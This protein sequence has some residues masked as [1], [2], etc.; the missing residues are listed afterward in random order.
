MTARI[1]RATAAATLREIHADLAARIPPLDTARVPRV[2]VIRMTPLGAASAGVRAPTRAGLTGAGEG[3][4]TMYGYAAVFDS[5]AVIRAPREGEFREVVAPGAFA[6]TLGRG[7]GRVRVMYN[8]GMDPSVGTKP[9]GRPSVI[10][11]DAT[12]L[13]VEVPID[14]TSYGRDIAASLRSGALDG[15]S[16]R[17]SVVRDRWERPGGRLPLRT[18]LEVELHE[19]GPVDWP[20]YLATTAGIRDASGYRQWLRDQAARETIVATA[21]RAARRITAAERRAL[22]AQLRAAARR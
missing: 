20:A 19:L 12:G 22:L 10:R 18:L 14:D 17:F 11:E 1:G 3:I 2:D 13:W 5:E 21:P 6:A 8:H 16:F 15:M 9:V 4:G 7:I